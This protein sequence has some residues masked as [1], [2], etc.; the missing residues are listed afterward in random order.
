MRSDD[1]RELAALLATRDDWECWILE[2][3]ITHQR[4]VL[5]IHPGTYPR[6]WRVQCLGCAHIAGDVQGGP[7]RLAIQPTRWRGDAMNELVADDASFRVVCERFVLTDRRL[8]PGE[9]A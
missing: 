8:A 3:G 5:A 2:F 4:M 6:H 1:T 7:F 9:I